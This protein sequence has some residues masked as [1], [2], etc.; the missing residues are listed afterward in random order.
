MIPET[1]EEHTGGTMVLFKIISRYSWDQMQ[2]W[3]RA[4]PG[5]TVEHVMAGTGIYIL[6]LPAGCAR[7]EEAAA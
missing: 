1:V 5:S 6:H 4:C 7:G 2:A 3:H